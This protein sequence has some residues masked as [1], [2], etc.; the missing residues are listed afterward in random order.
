MKPGVMP[1]G[2]DFADKD[3]GR[4]IPRYACR[5]GECNNN[6]VGGSEFCAEHISPGALCGRCRQPFGHHGDATFKPFDGDSPNKDVCQTCGKGRAHHSAEAFV[7]M[8]REREASVVMGWKQ[9]ER[10]CV[11]VDPTN[12]RRCTN[13]A[14]NGI[15]GNFP[16][17][18]GHAVLA[19]RDTHHPVNHPAHYQTASGLEVIEVIEAFGLNFS[20]GNAVKYI[21][22]AGKKGDAVEDLKKAAWYLAREVMAVRGGDE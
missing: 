14:L 22:R 7:V 3:D 12:A 15:D 6:P 1:T 9:S 17:C 11:F 5:H 10:V 16:Y 20:L 4:A 21:L 13:N 19:V 18:G 2:G 8:G